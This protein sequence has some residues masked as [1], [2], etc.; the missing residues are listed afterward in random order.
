MRNYAVLEA[1]EAA[2]ELIAD[3]ATPDVSL[4][5]INLVPLLDGKMNER[6]EPI[7]FW[8]F[9]GDHE[10]EKLAKP[11]IA[12]ELQTG[13]TPLVKK[14][15][16]LLTRNFKNF[17]HPEIREQDFVGARAILTDDYKLV[18]EGEKGMGVEHK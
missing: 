16:G 5:G 6:G 12:P 13:T 2:A 17:H 1:W 18:I 9:R 8:Y 14:M 11:Y 15:G 7:K 10:A 4:D 3:A